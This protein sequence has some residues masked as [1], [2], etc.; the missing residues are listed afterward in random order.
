MA[1]GSL[2]RRKKALSV[3]MPGTNTSALLQA[4]LQMRDR[5]CQDLGISVVREDTLEAYIAKVQR[6]ATEIREA[7]K[8]KNFATAVS[9]VYYRKLALLRTKED[10]TWLGEYPKEAERRKQGFPAAARC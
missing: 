9:H 10:Y 7:V 6:G 1:A 8:E 3:S 4:F 2:V 5:V